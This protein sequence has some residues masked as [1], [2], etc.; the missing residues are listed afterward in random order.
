MHEK[1]LNKFEVKYRE[2]R[3][4]NVTMIQHFLETYK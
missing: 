2:L 3:N 1:L 4:V